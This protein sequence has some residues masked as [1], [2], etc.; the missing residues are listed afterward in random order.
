MVAI[1][2]PFRVTSHCYLRSD[3]LARMISDMDSS[4]MPQVFLMSLPDQ[5][6]D[7]V[8]HSGT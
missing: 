6:E 3:D 7:L 8:T 5:V 2:S 1:L 4:A